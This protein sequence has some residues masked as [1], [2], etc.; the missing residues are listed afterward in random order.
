MESERTDYVLLGLGV[1]LVLLPLGYV[2]A[3]PS[4]FAPA[5]FYLRLVASLG[6]ALIGACLPGL[7]HIRL[8]GIRAGG[9][10]AVLVLFWQFNPPQ[11]LNAAIRQRVAC[12]H[13]SHG[14]ERYA[15]TFNVDRNSSWMGGGYDQGKWC[16]D[17]IA[18]LRGEHP[19]GSFEIVGHSERSENKC[20]PFNC[21]QYMYFCTVKVSTDPIYVEKVS[22]ACGEGGNEPTAAI[23]NPALQPTGFAG[24]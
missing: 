22:S 15:R 1:L 16:N 13:P 21:P 10:L 18:S 4:F 20:P 17:V 6:G 14:I 3:F 12:R 9:A 11:L 7:L 24:G 8:P 23:A 2:V 5:Q 19:Q